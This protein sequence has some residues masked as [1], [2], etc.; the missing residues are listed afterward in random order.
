MLSNTNRTEIKKGA[1]KAVSDVSKLHAIID[2]SLIAHIAITNESGP[3]VIPMLAWRVGDYV[4]IHG[5]NNSRLLRSLKQ[6][7]QTCLTFTLFDGWVLARSAFHHSAHYRSAVVFGQFDMVENNQEKDRL[8]N[9]FIE[10]I[11]PGRTKQ[12]RLSN[13]KELKATMLLRIPLT[14][15][16]VKISNFGVNDDAEDM[17]IPVWAGVLPYRTVVGPLQACEDLY[18]GIAEPD[19]RSAYSNCWQE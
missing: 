13:E 6:G 5:A 15:A 17:D 7:V 3:V 4:Y 1:H 16:S 8:L 18:E 10:Q 12:V 11:A 19:Y 9:H 2:E 14:E